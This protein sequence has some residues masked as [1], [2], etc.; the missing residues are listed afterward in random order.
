MARARSGAPPQTRQDSAHN[1]GAKVIWT[2]TVK[3]K[4]DIEK[5]RK[6]LELVDKAIA[7]LLEHFPPKKKCQSGTYRPT[8]HGN[9]GPPSV[10]N[11][12][13]STCS[14]RIMIVLCSIPQRQ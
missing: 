6:S 12:L 11:S 10:S 8:D 7:K 1:L 14:L 5:K 9:N 13:P 4:L 2:G 3:E